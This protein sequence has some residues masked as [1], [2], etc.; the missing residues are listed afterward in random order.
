M[1]R[2]TRGER[3]GDKQK[4]TDASRG[5]KADWQL[6]TST[7]HGSSG[8]AEGRTCTQTSTPLF[9]YVNQPFQR[10]TPLGR[11]IL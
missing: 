2:S 4:L 8:S 1:K 7:H 3:V 5:R 10:V 9:Q 11:A 6:P